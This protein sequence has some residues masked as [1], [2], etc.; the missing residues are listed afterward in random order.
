[1][2]LCISVFSL[3]LLCLF[4]LDAQQEYAESYIHISASVSLAEALDEIESQT[5]YS[6]IYDARVINL[7]EKLRSPLSGRTVFEILN[8]LFKD[9][10]IV[11]TVMND[12]IILSKKE[13]IIQIQQKLDGKIKGIVTDHEGEPI[14]CVNVVEKGTKNGTITDVDGR[15][16]LYWLSFTRN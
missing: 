7:S 13:T 14:A 16:V 10:T 2:R 8:L 9:R 12:Q 3:L 6:F 1:M 11:Y 15:F 5:N 4:P